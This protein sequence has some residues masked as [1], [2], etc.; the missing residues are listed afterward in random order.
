MLVPRHPGLT[1]D[2]EVRP[3]M[4]DLPFWS[5]LTTKLG[6]ADR[7]QVMISEPAQGR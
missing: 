2:R 6:S 3:G 5:T 7:S 1:F 4:I